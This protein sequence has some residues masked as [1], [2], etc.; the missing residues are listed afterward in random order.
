MSFDNIK[1]AVIELCEITMKIK[2]LEARKKDLEEVVKPVL[3][4]K[5][6]LG[7]GDFTVNVKT[8]NGRKT[9][10]KEAVAAALGVPDLSPY[11]KVGKPYSMTTIERIQQA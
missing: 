1:P 6:K 2:E 5:G 4:D 8:M 9:L 10:D 7:F 11:E 3:A